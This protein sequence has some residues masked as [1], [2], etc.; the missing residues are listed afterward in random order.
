[1]KQDEAFREAIA[2]QR[3]PISHLRKTFTQIIAITGSALGPR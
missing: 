1:M 3:S 2:P